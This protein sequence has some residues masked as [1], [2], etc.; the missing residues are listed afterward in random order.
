IIF[1]DDITKSV[2]DKC[3][4]IYD[5]KQYLEVKKYIGFDYIN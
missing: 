5:G 2:S 3:D 1:F 4:L